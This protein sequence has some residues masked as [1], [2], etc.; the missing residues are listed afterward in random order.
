M[1]EDELVA[2]TMHACVSAV[3]ESRCEET[4][5]LVAHGVGGSWF[6]R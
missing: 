6:A 5:L 1:A 2:R 4:A 3:V